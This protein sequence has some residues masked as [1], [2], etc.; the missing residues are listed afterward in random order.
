[1]H[2]ETVGR[3]AGFAHI[4]HLGDHGA[5]NGRIDVG[6]LEHD[7]RRV[8][9]QFH[10]GLHDVV[11]RFMQQLTADFR[12]AGKRHDAHARVV[13]HRRDDLARRARRND[14]AD[15]GRHAGFFQRG[16]QRQHR[17]RGV[18]GGLEYD[19]AAC[20]ERR[21]DFTGRHRGG[22]IPW[23]DEDADARRLVMRQDARA[24]RGRL[25][26]LPEIAHGFF[27]IPAEEFGG[28]GDLGA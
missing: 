27:G 12:R 2:V 8:A 5:F 3:R 14:V 25:R 22:E 19:G 10:R 4:A 16:H 18:G 1:M 20:G 23:R 13:Q 9:A 6:I 7:E 28:V 21:T 17:Q 26:H 15:A 24:G 11:S